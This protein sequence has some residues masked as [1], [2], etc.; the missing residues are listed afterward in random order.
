MFVYCTGK[1]TILKNDPS[2][3]ATVNLMDLKL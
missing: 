2:L 3:A 1:V